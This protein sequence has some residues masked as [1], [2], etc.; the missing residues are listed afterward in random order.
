MKICKGG[1]QLLFGGGKV[2]ALI[3]VGEFSEVDITVERQGGV[4]SIT[5]IYLFGQELARKE[6]EKEVRDN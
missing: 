3:A 5:S 4:Y 2:V 6:R 1:A